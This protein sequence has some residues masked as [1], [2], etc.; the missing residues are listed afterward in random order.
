M[1]LLKRSKNNNHNLYNISL[2]IALNMSEIIKKYL[3]YF[4]DICVQKLRK[5]AL[6]ADT[7]FRKTVQIPKIS[8]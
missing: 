6:L 7:H 4:C 3:D 5:Q 2:Y 1:S 8:I